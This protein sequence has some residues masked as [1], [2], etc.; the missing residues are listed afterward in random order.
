LVSG[1]EKVGGQAGAEATDTEKH[2]GRRTFIGLVAAGL[3]ALFLG[4]EIFPH[5]SAWLSGSVNTGRFRINSVAAGPDFDP[6]TWRLTVD[7]LVRKPLKLTFAQ[8]SGL[9]QVEFTRDFDCVEGWGV[10]DVVWKGVAMREVLQ[11]ADIDPQATT[12][13]FHSSDLVY[14]DSLT[15]EE[16]L[17]PDTVLAHEMNGQPLEPGMGRPLRLVLPGNYGYK[18][19]KWVLRVEAIAPGTAGYKG[20]WENYGYPVDASIR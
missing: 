2:I 11:R 16:A 20:Y 18:Y 19:V 3:A 10:K 6:A 17:R 13:V 1:E 5:I 14:T 15:L 4:K 7:G 8:F 9:P 12:L